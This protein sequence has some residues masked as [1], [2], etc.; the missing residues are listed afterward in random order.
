MFDTIFNL[1]IGVFGFM[2]ILGIWLLLQAV[3]RRNSGCGAGKD[4]LDYLGHGCGGCKGSGSC[5]KRKNTAGGETPESK[6]KNHE[7]V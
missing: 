3:I 6:W 7:L 4:V 2:A 1:L 5:T